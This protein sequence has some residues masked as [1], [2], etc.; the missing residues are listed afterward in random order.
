LCPILQGVLKVKVTIS[1]E[2]N[3]DLRSGES[4]TAMYDSFMIVPTLEE[5]VTMSVSLSPAMV[6][7]I[8]I[9]VL[10]VA[11]ISSSTALLAFWMEKTQ[12]IQTVC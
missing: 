7:S 12:T 2:A 10:L 4:A 5:E 9:S 3:N 1:D 11:S 6:I 8:S